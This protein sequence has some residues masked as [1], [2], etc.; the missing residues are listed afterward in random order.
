MRTR[1][2]VSAMVAL[3]TLIA[4]LCIM[5]MTAVTANAAWV[6]EGIAWM[7]PATG[8]TE[9]Y[10]LANPRTGLHHYTTDANER[11]VL[12]NKRHW[13]YE[14]VAFHADTEGQPVY[15]V[16]NPRSQKHNY[17]MDS[18]ERDILV[19]RHGW[20]YEGISWYVSDSATLPVY[21]ALNQSN[22]EHLWTVDAKEYEALGK[23]PS[24]PN[25]PN[26]KPSTPSKPQTPTVQNGI[27]PGAF[28]SPEGAKGIGKKNGVT[29]TC[30][31][32]DNGILRWRR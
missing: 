32:D 18:S 10:R 26:N 16:Y 30:K 8:G 7:A 9:V 13:T 20:Q 2:I 24:K 14:G 5:P 1:K 6:Q 31:Y 29:Y 15:R 12:K 23:K 25:T 11:D 19:Q 21:R 17:T 22:G 28:C 4:G 3:L 27:T